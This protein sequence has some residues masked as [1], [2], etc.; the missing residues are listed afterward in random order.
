M[1][2]TTPIVLT[3][4]VMF[5]AAKKAFNPWAWLLAGSPLGAIVI[6]ALPSA[7]MTKFEPAICQKRRKRGTV[8]GCVLSIVGLVFHIWLLL[9]YY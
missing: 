3:F 5:I 7:D 6:M 1:N 9:N 4:V 8:T 2:F